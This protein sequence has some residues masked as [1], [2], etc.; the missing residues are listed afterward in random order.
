MAEEE[1]PPAPPLRL[2]SN[3]GDFQVSLPVDMRPLPKEP[4][5]KIKHIKGK[6]KK[7]KDHHYEKPNIS[8]PTKFT[9]VVHVG[10]DDDSGEF[11][12]MPEAWTKLLVASNISKE[13]QMQNPQ[14]VLDVLNYYEHSSKKTEDKYMTQTPSTDPS[15]RPSYSVSSHA[16]SSPS[17]QSSQPV[18]GVSPSPPVS[19][20]SVP[21]PVLPE[22]PL[23]NNASSTSQQPA[24]RLT[25][26]TSNTPS[27]FSTTPDQDDTEEDAE[28]PPPPI[29]TRP[30][31][32][33]S[34]YTKPVDS[35]EE[36][37][38]SLKLPPTINEN[39]LYDK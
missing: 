19:C 10:F 16:L 1:K 17:S 22:P 35:D 39:D 7:G 4:E 36:A 31:R 12:G 9:H 25:S 18:S 20:A 32:T 24:N 11:T 23:G 13:M 29:A 8:Y 6:L 38:P 5:E 28:P 26:S 37:T 30:E 21:S 33:K 3:R 34:I 2:T 15:P 27:V 14:A